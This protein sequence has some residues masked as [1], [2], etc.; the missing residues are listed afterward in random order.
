[1]TW[2]GGKRFTAVVLL[3][4]SESYVPRRMVDVVGGDRRGTEQLPA[5]SDDALAP[6]GD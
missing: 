1:M 3:L 5:S 6:H 4:K 2:T